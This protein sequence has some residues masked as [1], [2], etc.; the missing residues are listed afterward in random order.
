MK[1]A[2]IG[3]GAA[4]IMAAL[5]LARVDAQVTLFEQ[6]PSVGK[7]I[8]VTGS[9]RCNLSNDAV[10]AEAYHCADSEWMEKFLETLV[11]LN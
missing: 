9:G 7:K 4:G 2:V 5:S 10:C 3:A 1:I 6:N 11:F 8:L